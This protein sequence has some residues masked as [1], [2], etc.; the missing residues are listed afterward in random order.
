MISMFEV[1][2]VVEIYRT[3]RIDLVPFLSTFIVSLLYG[4]DFGILAGTLVNFLMIIFKSSR[5]QIKFELDIVNE[6]DVLIVTPDQSLN[7]SS[8]E[9]FKQ[10]ILTRII[11]DFP[12]VQ[13]VLINGISI[14]DS[15]DITVVKVSFKHAENCLIKFLFLEYFITN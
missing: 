11:H 14:N 12:T 8:A 5:P 9:F 3:R 13:I 4:V 10:T 7:Y 15:V 1:S 2:E 6:F